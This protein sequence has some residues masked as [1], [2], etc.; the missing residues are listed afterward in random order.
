M[1]LLGY[2]MA[3]TYPLGPGEHD[4]NEPEILAAVLNELILE[5]REER[6]A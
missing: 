6:K 2:R 1:C 4:G 5:L 3:A